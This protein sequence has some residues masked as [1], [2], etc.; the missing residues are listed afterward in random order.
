MNTLFW[1]LIVT[2]V[3]LPRV[4]R[5]LIRRA[6][7]TP[8]RAI[9]SAD[10][11]EIYLARYWLFNPY[12][13]AYEKRWSWL[14]S[15]R[16]H[17]IMRADQD[18]HMHSHPYQARTIILQGWYFEEVPRPNGKGRRSHCREIGYT[19]RLM[20]GT[21]HRISC[22]PWDGVWTLF[23]T[24]GATPNGWGFLVNGKHVQHS[25]YLKARQ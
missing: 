9:V 5:W 16:A 15:I 7:R 21:Y 18:R 6:M 12:D 25:E 4:R 14:P 17:R 11:Q 10:G 19:G 20:P 1:R 13:G 8:Y 22:V 2:I 23:F 24:W 3:T